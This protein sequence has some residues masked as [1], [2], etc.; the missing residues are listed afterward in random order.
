MALSNPQLR[1]DIAIFIK[2][3]GSWISFHTT[4]PGTNGGNEA[5]GG[6]Y[7]RK[8]TTWTDGAVD[9]IVTGAAVEISVPAGTWAWCGIWSAQTGG[10]WVEKFPVNST[11]LSAAGTILVTPTLGPVS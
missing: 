2:G 9:G 8:Q 6:G 7:A 10:T 3:K 1:E 11:T 5:S 4:D